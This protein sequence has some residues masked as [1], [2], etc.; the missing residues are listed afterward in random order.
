MSILSSVVDSAVDLVSGVIV[1]C[2]NRAIRLTNIYNYPLGKFFVHCILESIMTNALVFVLYICIVTG[3]SAG[4]FSLFIIAF[5]FTLPQGRNRLE[6]VAILLLSSIMGSASVLVVRESTE[7]II[8]GNISIDLSVVSI[9]IVVCKWSLL[10]RCFYVNIEMVLIH[11][12]AKTS[13]SKQ[14]LNLH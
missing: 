1:W 11:K 2:T 7:K 12:I 4:W 9:S 13:L 6:P 8:S 5:Y 3:N 10:L 14:E